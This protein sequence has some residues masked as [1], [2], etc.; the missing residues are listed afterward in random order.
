MN[1]L[2]IVELK[3]D[4]SL[5]DVFGAINTYKRQLLDLRVA[6]WQGQEKVNTAIIGKYK[7]EIAR[8]KTKFML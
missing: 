7:R 5:G 4:A 6:M 3:P 2:K 1:K 8:L